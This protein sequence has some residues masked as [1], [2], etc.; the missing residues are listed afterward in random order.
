MSC[1]MIWAD[2]ISLVIFIQAFLFKKTHRMSG[3][4]FYDFFMGAQLNPR[5]LGLDL[6]MWAEIRVSWTLLFILTLSSALK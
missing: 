6:K 4:L 2:V 5:I 3:N 1:S